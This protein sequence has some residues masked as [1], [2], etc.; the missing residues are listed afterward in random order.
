MWFE[1]KII[2]ALPG[3]SQVAGLLRG[4]DRRWR[5]GGRGRRGWPLQVGQGRAR[6]TAALPPLRQ[7]LQER[8]GVSRE[9]LLPKIAHGCVNRVI[10]NHARQMYGAS[11]LLH[12]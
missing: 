9:L 8:R 2:M 4:R 3:H 11:E 12:A 1:S 7:R 10:G 5:P 6:Q